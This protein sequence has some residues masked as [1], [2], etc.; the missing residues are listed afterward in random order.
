LDTSR[1][2]PNTNNT[3]DINININKT[4][5]GTIQAKRIAD[6]FVVRD[7]KNNTPIPSIKPASQNRSVTK[8]VMPPK[9]RAVK[10]TIENNLIMSAYDIKKKK[11][12]PFSSNPKRDITIGTGTGLAVLA[13]LTLMG[14][15]KRITRKN[16]KQMYT[17]KRSPQK[18]RGRLFSL[19]KRRRNK[20]R[21]TKRK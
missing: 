7:T 18:G 2:P 20:K 17:R 12:A 8:K 4:S 15:K 6:D 9:V 21:K 10:K 1:T 16:K 19:N 11:D 3:S 13:G 5:P 14:G